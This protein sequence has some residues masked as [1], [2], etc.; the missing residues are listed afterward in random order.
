MDDD[1]SRKCR[2]LKMPMCAKSAQTERAL[3]QMRARLIKITYG[4]PTC[5]DCKY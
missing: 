2:D 5:M 1:R 4:A 3:E